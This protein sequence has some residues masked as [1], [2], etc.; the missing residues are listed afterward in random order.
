MIDVNNLRNI[1]N[2]SIISKISDEFFES[3]LCFRR[4]YLIVNYIISLFLT[5]FI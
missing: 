1:D 3:H 4:I 2:S 5:A